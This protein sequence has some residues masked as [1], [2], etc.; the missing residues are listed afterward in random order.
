MPRQALKTRVGAGNTLAIE[1]PVGR[2]REFRLSHR[3]GLI[4]YD[5]SLLPGLSIHLIQSR[6]SIEEL[7]VS[8][9]GKLL[10]GQS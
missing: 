3:L 1:R 2:Y 5:L 6:G 8:N 4:L 9:D 7:V 10:H